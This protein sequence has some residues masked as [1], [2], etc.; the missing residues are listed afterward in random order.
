MKTTSTV[1]KVFRE[2]CSRKVKTNQHQVC[3][4]S[5][6]AIIHTICTKLITERYREIK[7]QHFPYM[8][9]R[10]QSNTFPFPEQ[11]NSDISLI[12]SGFNNFFSTKDTNIFPDENLNSFFTECNS[13]R[14]PFKHS[15][16]PVSVDFKYYDISDFDKLN[17]SKN[18][19]SAALHLNIESLSK[20]FDNLQNF[21]SLLKHYFDFIDISKHKVNKNS[22]NINFYSVRIYFLF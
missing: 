4:T 3:C 12:N 16:Y 20:Y 10:C 18:F 2:L 21:L 8:S 11:Q 22:M 1:T 17:K 19:S 9:L 14:T 7:K 15:D 5:C 6:Q 13:I